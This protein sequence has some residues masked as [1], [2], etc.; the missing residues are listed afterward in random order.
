MT[1]FVGGLRAALARTEVR[2]GIAA[3]ALLALAVPFQFP[4]TRLHAASRLESSPF[5][6]TSDLDR[7]VLEKKA[8]FL[9][10][11]KEN[12]LRFFSLGNDA[13]AASYVWIKAAGYVT[14]EFGTRTGAAATEREAASDREAS[15]ERKFEWLSKLYDTVLDLDPHWVG[16]CRVGAMILAAVG[17]DPSGAIDLLERGM[18]A[19]P[20]SWIL[21]YEAGVTMLMWPGHE[22]EAARYFKMAAQ[23][24]MDPERKETIRHIIP[25]LVAEAGRLEEA[26]RL[27]RKRAFDFEGQAIG[28]ASKG[29]LREF[30]SRQLELDL[31]EAVAEFREREGRFPAD[32]AEI[33]RAGLLAKFDFHF[34]EAIFVFPDRLDA[35]RG[36]FRRMYPQAPTLK[37]LTALARSGFLHKMVV[38]GL[39]EPPEWR[40]TYGKPFLYH[41]PS[42]TLRSEGLAEVDATGTARIL[43]SAAV[44]FRMRMGRRPKSLQEL[45]EHFWRR[46]TR[47]GQ[48]RSEWGP[49]FENGRPP[50]HPLAAWGWAYEYDAAT[51]RIDIR[52]GRSDDAAHRA[53][54]EQ[55]RD[56]VRE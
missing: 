4:A 3:A 14:R 17:R 54:R 18:G 13:L 44:A 16:A 26:I 34:T 56:G 12:S 9:Y 6:W 22:E 24:P 37:D 48:L 45:T 1:R 55:E 28:E 52:E 47:G 29:R 49:V 25:R 10:L 39:F 42:G 35:L 30:V 20:D 50:D 51:G 2:F 53:G 33:R 11:P 40:D 43:N 38:A 27:A 46:I 23:R 19:N 32:V 7:Q 15:A 41:A 8:Y 31:E 36:L 21:P 5:K